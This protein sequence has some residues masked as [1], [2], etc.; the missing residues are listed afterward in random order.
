MADEVGANYR[1]AACLHCTTCPFAVGTGRF[2]FVGN[3]DDRGD[4]LSQ[5]IRHQL[6]MECQRSGFHA[7]AMLNDLAGPGDRFCPGSRI[8]TSLEPVW[9]SP[10]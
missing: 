6:Q 1:N 4:D 5:A 8:P 3:L 10:M 7:I 9:F 2:R